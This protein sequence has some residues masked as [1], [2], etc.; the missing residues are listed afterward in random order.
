MPADINARIKFRAA[1]LQVFAGIEREFTIQPKI[2]LAQAALESNWG[3]SQLATE[4]FNI[5][6]ITPGDAWLAFMRNERKAAD[7][8]K[9][10]SLGIET[11]HFPTTEYSEVA[12]EHIHYWE[13][14]GDIISK[15]PNGKGGS[16]CTVERHFRKYAT[17]DESA[18]DWARKIAQTP[19]YM[20][21][22]EAAKA[23]DMMAFGAAL[24][25][26]GYATDAG[27]PAEL[28][29]EWRAID[30]LPPVVS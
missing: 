30:A 12:P 15:K 14:P 8:P 17:W 25:K 10:S 6:S 1:T 23:G 22:Y 4:G 29:M 5:F 18:W 20:Y 7:V 9:W 19:R 24:E 21:A 2:G 16:I 26:A 13:F 28:L 11:I 27:Y 3:L